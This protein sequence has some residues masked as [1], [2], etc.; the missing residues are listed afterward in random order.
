VRVCAR[1][2]ACIAF[3]ARARALARA[4]VP[5]SG[6]TAQQRE[7]SVCTVK[8]GDSLIVTSASHE[9][10]MVGDFRQKQIENRLRR[11]MAAQCV[12]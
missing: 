12:T 3:S 11:N 9:N 6:L 10:F 4:C 7:I 2:R 5:F 8:D 1:V